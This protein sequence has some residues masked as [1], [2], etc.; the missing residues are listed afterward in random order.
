M[1]IFSSI[2]SRDSIVIF[3]SQVI[4]LSRTGWSHRLAR[5]R[6]PVTSILGHF[7]RRFS[8][9]L[10]AS[11]RA[12]LFSRFSIARNHRTGLF[13]NLSF[14][15]SLLS[16]AATHHRVSHGRTRAIVAAVGVSYPR[17]KWKFSRTER[18]LF[19]FRARI[20]STFAMKSC[21]MRRGSIRTTTA[22]QSN[23]SPLID[24]IFRT[25]Q[26]LARSRFTGQITSLFTKPGSKK[27]RRR[28]NRLYRKAPR[29]S[30]AR[31]NAENCFIIIF[32]I[33]K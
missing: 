10:K 27:Q 20:S 18:V 24:A 28:I 12:H 1:R 30:R 19:L 31:A 15:F 32:F 7:P 4:I 11:T 22:C 14:R 33:W 6:F 3:F 23:S 25:L 21:Q 17:G 16:A 13:V 9:S 2:G 5:F 29:T 26:Y 8:R